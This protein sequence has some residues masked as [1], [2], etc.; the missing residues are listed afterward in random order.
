[1]YRILVHQYFW[2]SSA[3]SDVVAGNKGPV[4]TCRYSVATKRMTTAYGGV[5][6][7]HKGKYVAGYETS[8]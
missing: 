7:I 3:I 8:A 5:N 4:P 1:M 2:Q 6:L